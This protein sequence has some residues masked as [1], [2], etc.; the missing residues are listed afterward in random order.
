MKKD[1][2]QD[3]RN[4]ANNAWQEYIKNPT[5]E[6]KERLDRLDDELGIELK[7]DRYWNDNVLNI[8]DGNS[9]KYSM[10]YT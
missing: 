6:N 10:D 9:V 7:L 1:V 8:N 3:L 5:T 2:I 4:L